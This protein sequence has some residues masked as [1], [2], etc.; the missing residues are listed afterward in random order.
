MSLWNVEITDG[1]A[2]ASYNNPPMNYMTADGMN[3]LKELIEQWRDPD[4]RVVVLTGALPDRFITHYSVEELVESARDKAMMMNIGRAWLHHH[5]NTL[6]NLEHLPK[7]IIAAM[8]GSTMGGGFETSLSCDIR[9][10]QQG[11]YRYGLP[12]VTLGILPGGCGTQR[13][14]RLIGAGRAIDFILRGRICRPDEAL[15]MGIIHEV[16]ADAK[17]RAIEIAN[18]MVGLSA[19]AIAETKRAVYEGSEVHMQGGLEI[20]GDAFIHTMVTD[21]AVAIMEEYVAQDFDDRIAW[22][23]RKKGLLHPR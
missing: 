4:V 23:E 18:E 17:A 7:P 16:A 14:S 2:V 19:V 10:G 5:N 20:E 1:V 13:L 8:T 12:E 3:G 22:L 15:S 6:T 21:E 11:D 9:I